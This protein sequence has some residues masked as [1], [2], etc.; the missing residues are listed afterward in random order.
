MLISYKNYNIVSL[1][2]KPVKPFF[3]IFRVQFHLNSFPSFRV[4]MEQA[5]I[6]INF[7]IIILVGLVGYVHVLK[8]VFVSLPVICLTGCWQVYTLNRRYC[9]NKVTVALTKPAEREHTRYGIL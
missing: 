6:L 5:S 2:Y 7:H 9:S 8:P 1:E 4:K 3:L